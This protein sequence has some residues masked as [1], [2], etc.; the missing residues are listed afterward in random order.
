[1]RGNRDI[2][3]DLA[4]VDHAVQETAKENCS[5]GDALGVL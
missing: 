1:L 4:E 5:V 2:H 3:Q